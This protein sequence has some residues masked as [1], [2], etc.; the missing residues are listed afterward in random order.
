MK[1][2]TDRSSLWKTARHGCKTDHREAAGR[3]SMS[4]CMCFVSSMAQP[5]R[6][7]RTVYRQVRKNA[8][9]SFT[10]SWPSSTLICVKTSFISS[11]QSARSRF[12]SVSKGACGFSKLPTIATAMLVLFSIAMVGAR[13]LFYLSVKRSKKNLWA[14]TRA[15][16]ANASWQ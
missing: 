8:N 7:K 14:K 13:R 12:A 9:A 3:T 6:M 4:D 15:I 11:K 2:S 5:S 1:R 10:S 16:S